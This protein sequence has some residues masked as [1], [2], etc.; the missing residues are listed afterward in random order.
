MKV[1]YCAF[2]VRVPKVAENLQI[3]KMLQKILMHFTVPGFNLLLQSR[4]LLRFMNL[5]Q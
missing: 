4:F 3:V 5:L 1:Q 2:S